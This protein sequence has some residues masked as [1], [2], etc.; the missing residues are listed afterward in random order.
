M[1]RKNNIPSKKE[2][3]DALSKVYSDPEIQDNQ[4]L[5]KVIFEFA[6]KFNENSDKDLMYICQHY[7][8]DLMLNYFFMKYA[9]KGIPHSLYELS[10]V[11]DRVPPMYWTMGPT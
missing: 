4:E 2:V 3:M 8:G 10:K 9:D 6:Q 11:I 5:L 7:S 1:K